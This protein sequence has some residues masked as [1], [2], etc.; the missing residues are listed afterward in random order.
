MIGEGH[1]YR[2]RLIKSGVSGAILSYWGKHQTIA[3]S[4]SPGVCGSYEEQ[5]RTIYEEKADYACGSVPLVWTFASGSIYKY[6]G[7]WNSCADA[8]HS[9]CWTSSLIWSNILRDEAW[10]PGATPIFGKYDPSY[11]CVTSDRPVGAW[12]GDH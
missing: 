6:E 10:N 5:S 7:E 12:Q 11:P 4:D 2:L 9:H 3:W 8:D 1:F